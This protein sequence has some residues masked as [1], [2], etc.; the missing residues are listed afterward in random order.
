M[1]TWSPV[2]SARREVCRFAPLFTSTCTDA[3]VADAFDFIAFND[4]PLFPEA[5]HEGTG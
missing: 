2:H 5:G 4:M 3:V 1:A